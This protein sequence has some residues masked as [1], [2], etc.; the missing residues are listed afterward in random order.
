[1][2]ITSGRKPGKFGDL[3]SYGV[4]HGTSTQSCGFRIPES[5]EF[6]RRPDMGVESGGGGTSPVEKSAGDVPQNRGY[7]SMFSWLV[8]KL[9]IFQ[10]FKKWPKSEEKLIFVVGGFGCQWIRYPNQNFVVTLLRADP[11]RQIQKIGGIEAGWSP[12]VKWIW[13]GNGWKWGIICDIFMDWIQTCPWIPK[14]EPG[15]DPKDLDP[16]SVWIIDPTLTVCRQIHWDHRSAFA[17][18]REIHSDP[19]AKTPFC[20]GIHR[21][22]ISGK[23]NSRNFY[24]F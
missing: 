15:S 13:S 23:R 7:F 18:M 17:I 24:A 11:D 21:D 12:S 5:V 16:G 8:L 10:H 1:M 2:T 9:C 20:V 19:G 14:T 3:L 6:I 4:E 22:P